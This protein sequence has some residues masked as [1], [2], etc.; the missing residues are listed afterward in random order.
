MNIEILNQIASIQKRRSIIEKITIRTTSKTLIRPPGLTNIMNASC[1]HNAGVQLLYRIVELRNFI[2]DDKI[3][4]QYKDDSFIHNIIELFKLMHGTKDEYLK[5][6]E[7]KDLVDICLTK[8]LN[9]GGN[10]QDTHEFLEIIL[11][12]LLID[13]AADFQL[14][15][16]DEY[17]NGFDQIKF[18]EED[19]PRNLFKTLYVDKRSYTTN[20]GIYLESIKE[21][22]S[23]I[24]QQEFDL[25]SSEKL[26]EIIM[27]KAK[28]QKM[29]AEKE[30]KKFTQ[31]EYDREKNNYSNHTKETFGKTLPNIVIKDKNGEYVKIKV[32]TKLDLYDKSNKNYKVEKEDVDQERY[33]I[34]N[35]YLIIQLKVFDEYLNKKT[36]NIQVNDFKYPGT[37]YE[38]EFVGKII[39]HGMDIDGGH[40]VANIKYND[41]WYLYN[42]THVKNT[43]KDDNGIGADPTPYI[44]LFKRK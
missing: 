19:D 36:H 12:G 21:D 41:Q 9:W 23:N 1:F 26:E 20:D 33:Y 2:M 35:E 7:I 18:F 43:D 5:R 17:C 42:D 16:K 34:P 29:E 30:I 8:T 39:H 24:I 13:C 44:L 10:Q 37:N 15:N 31:E 22:R 27:N 6:D 32:P 14:K 40:Y 28:K 11:N 25:D 3:K 38:Y 4:N